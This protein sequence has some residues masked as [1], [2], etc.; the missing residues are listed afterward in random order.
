MTVN[1]EWRHDG[2]YAVTQ[3]G[4]AAGPFPTH[5]QAL[6]YA[7]AREEHYRDL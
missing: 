3:D 7:E 2:Y 5:D 4:I 6:A 1:V